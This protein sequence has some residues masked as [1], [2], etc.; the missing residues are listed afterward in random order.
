MS[1]SAI[2]CKL[3]LKTVYCLLAFK[4]GNNIDCPQKKT[5]VHLN[6]EADFVFEGC[7][8]EKIWF[9]SLTMIYINIF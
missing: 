2:G 5:M 4:F 8:V 9:P 6:Q 1:L 3:D 7:K